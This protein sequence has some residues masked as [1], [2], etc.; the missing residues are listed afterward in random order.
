MGVA[1]ESQAECLRFHIVSNLI[2]TRL[3]SGFDSGPKPEAFL[4][5]GGSPVGIACVGGPLPKLSFNHLLAPSQR[6]AVGKALGWFGERLQKLPQFRGRSYAI[7]LG[8][9]PRS[10]FCASW[11]RKKNG[12][13]HLV[14]TS[15]PQVATLDF[16]VFLRLTL[17]SFFFEDERAPRMGNK[18]LGH[19]R[20]PERAFLFCV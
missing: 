13:H 16:S 8:A 14:M 6:V 7:N 9:T 11:R 2:L 20:R 17:L 4:F 12:T 15:R 1:W 3:Q 5:Q 18:T 19:V 10:L